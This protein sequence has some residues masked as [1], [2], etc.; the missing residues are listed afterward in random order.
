MKELAVRSSAKITFDDGVDIKKAAKIAAQN[1]IVIVF[2]TQWMAE[3]LDSNMQLDGN[4][5]AL[6]AAVAKAN[7]HT[8][9]VLENGAPV[10]MPWL[11][12]VSAV[13]EAWYPGTSGGEAIA[14]VLTGEVNPS[15]HLPVTF[16]QSL[17]QLPRPVLDGDIK[18]L[19]L[20]VD[21]NYNIEGAAVGY[22]WF[23]RQNLKPLFPFG[24]GLSYTNFDFSDL[25]TE[26]KDNQLNVNFK[27]RNRGAVSGLDVAQV[28]VAPANAQTGKG[29]E[30]PKR[31]AGFKKVDLKPEQTTDVS[32]SVD[33]RLLAVYD[34]KQKSWTIA[35]GDYNVSLATDASTPVSTVKVHLPLQKFNVRGEAISK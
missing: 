2:A 21:V 6:I 19:T 35:E 4:Q 17:A 18:Q 23:D 8:I 22:K 26:L 10:L 30:S 12:K 28:Y 32:L 1:D 31:L 5:D 3:S 13:L 33:P 11:D 25:K 9:V 24:F 14:R 15:G 7:H 29:W 27:I 34:S 20:R 16:P